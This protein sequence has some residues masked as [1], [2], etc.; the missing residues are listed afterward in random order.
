MSDEKEVQP[1]TPE[2]ELQS[3]PPPQRGGRN[4]IVI[5]I[6]A[7]AL[8]GMI[9]VGL[10]NSRKGTAGDAL[11][12]NAI[13]KTAPDFELKDVNTGKTVK[14]SDYRGKAV[15]VNFWAT[16][17]SPCKVEIP[18]FVDLQKQYGADGLVILGVAMDDASQQDIAKF[19]QD[20]GVNYPILLGT[21]QVGDSYGG[22]QGLPTTIYVGRDGKII[23]RV[24]GLRSHRDVESNIKAA[25]AQ[26][27]PVAESMNPAGTIPA[28]SPGAR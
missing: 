27:R 22:V 19:A 21:Q 1:L 28:D 20:M 10:H 23:D 6:M 13:G 17:C 12:G 3:S 14:L 26:G 24:E 8:A 16:W 11:V 9:F 4:W 7:A 15:L 2:T 5:L 18:W 25:L